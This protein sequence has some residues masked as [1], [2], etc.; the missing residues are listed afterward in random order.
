MHFA[1]VL[2]GRTETSSPF[3]AFEESLQRAVDSR[4][5]HVFDWPGNGHVPQ[6][7]D[8]FLPC[9][10]LRK[11]FLYSVPSVQFPD[12]FSCFFSSFVRTL[13]RVEKADT[14][15]L[16]GTSH[17]T[18]KGA[19][20][21]GAGSAACEL[22]RRSRRN[23]TR[24]VAPAAPAAA[25]LA[26]VEAAPRLLRGRRLPLR[27]R[28]RSPPPAMNAPPLPRFAP[29]TRAAAGSPPWPLG[30]YGSRISGCCC[31]AG[32]VSH[33]RTVRLAELPPSS[34]FSLLCGYGFPDKGYACI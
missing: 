22:P 24:L 23:R 19:A 21:V 31:N 7:A 5:A 16:V 8:L 6:W 29:D 27:A 2:G 3:F 18:R 15:P 20:A 30:F 33:L 11:A 12:I 10:K 17:A 26:A 13:C 9:S 14:L 28:P 34:S 32:R 4:L 1:R 25:S